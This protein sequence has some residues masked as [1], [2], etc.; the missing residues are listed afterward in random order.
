MPNGRRRGADHERRTATKLGGYRVPY[1]GAGREKGD[2]LTDLVFAECKSSART[3]A[4]GT[5]SITV[6]KDT[7]EKMLLQQHAS[8]RPLH[9]LVLHLTGDKRDW[10]V[11]SYDQFTKLLTDYVTG[12]GTSNEGGLSQ[13]GICS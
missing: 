2:V 8:G 3:T 1:S 10:V 7:L 11:M 9:A 5:K 4:D 12:N 6:R 13:Q